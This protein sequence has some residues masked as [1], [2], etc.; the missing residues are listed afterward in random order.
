MGLLTNSPA[1]LNRE[2]ETKWTNGEPTEFYASAA[3]TATLAGEAADPAETRAQGC[4]V[5]YE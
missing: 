2:G 3:I 1:R 5:V 4:S